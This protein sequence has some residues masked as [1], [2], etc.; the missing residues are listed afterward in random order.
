MLISVLCDKSGINNKILLDKVK[1]LIKMT[2]DVYEPKLCYRIIIEAG[3][4][5]KNLKAVAECLDEVSL[6]IK[7]NGVEFCTKKDFALFLK[8]TDSSDKGVRENSLKVFSEAYLVL[9]EDIWRLLSKDVPL[10]VR[11]LLEQRFKQ[12]QKKAGGALGA[13]IN[14]NKSGQNMKLTQ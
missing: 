11:G 9:G 3:V 8:T 6:F 5:N 12:V 13:S 14:S 4:N 7:D 1:K 10:K 2:Y